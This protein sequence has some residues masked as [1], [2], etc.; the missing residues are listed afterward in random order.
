MTQQH[1]FIVTRVALF[2]V[3]DGRTI[4]KGNCACA[5]VGADGTPPRFSLVCY[6][7]QRETYCTSPIKSS[8]EHSLQFQLQVNDYASFRDDRGKKWSMM[9]LKSAQLEKFCAI[10]GAA[11]FAVSGSP[12]HNAVIADFAVPTA[13]VKVTLAHRVKVRYSAFALRRNTATDLPTVDDLLETN[14]DRPYNFQPTQSAMANPDAKGFESCCLGMSEE[15]S[16]VIVVPSRMPRAGSSPYA[17]QTDAVVF[18]VTVLRILSD[19]VPVEG[20]NTVPVVFGALTVA[21]SSSSA[22]SMNRGALTLVSP[23]PREAEAVPAPVSGTTGAVGSGIPAEHMAMIQKCGAQINAITTQARDMHDKVVAFADD[24]KQSVNRPKPSAL[25]NESLQ[26]NIKQMV[27]EHDRLKDEIVRRDEL[28]RSIDDRNRDLQK[29]VDT[30]AMVAQQLMDEKNNTV[31]AASDLK[32]D[33]DR[34]VMKLQEQLTHVGAERDDVNRHLLTVKKLLE[35]SDNELREIRGKIDVHL[36]QAQSLAS[37]LDVADDTLGEERSRRKALE[38]KVGALQDEIRTSEADLHMKVAQLEDLNRKADGERTYQVQIMEDERTRRQYEAQQL[39]SEIVQELQQREAKFLADRAR[40]AEDHFKRGHDE[41]KQIGRGNAKIDV[42][43]RMEELVLD[44]Q[45]A[46]TELD[47]Y[48]T[49]HRQATEES[50]AENRRLEC[51]VNELKKSVDE[52]TRR[53]AQNEFNLHA[54]RLKVRNAEEALLV[55]LTSV[56]HR[57]F[58]PAEPKDLIA[59]LTAIKNGD[60]PLLRF[61]QDAHQ[62]EAAAAMARRLQLIDTTA[63]DLYLQTVSNT[64]D[65]F[66]REAA[67]MNDTF[68]ATFGAMWRQRDAAAVQ[69]AVDEESSTRA[70]VEGESDSFFAELTAFFQQQWTDREALLADEEEARLSSDRDADEEVAAFLSALRAF[71]ATQAE[72]RRAVESDHEVSYEAFLTNADSELEVHFADVRALM[73]RQRQ[74]RSA[75]EE[76]EEQIR[77]QLVSECEAELQSS[78][79]GFFEFVQSIR[80]DREALEAAEVDGRRPVEEDETTT[81]AVIVALWASQKEERDTLVAEEEPL[82]AQYEADE[83]TAYRKIIAEHEAKIYEDLIAEQNEFFEGETA[84]RRAIEEDLQ[85]EE[86][87]LRTQLEASH[88]EHAARQKDREAHEKALQDCIQEESSARA[89]VEKSQGTDFQGIER[90]RKRDEEGPQVDVGVS[91]LNRGSVAMPPPPLGGAGAIVSDDSDSDGGKPPPKRAV[92]PKK[93]AA[94]K[95]ATVAPAN[96]FGSDSDDDAPKPPPKKMAKKMMMKPAKMFDSDS[97]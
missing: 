87:A 61:Q 91:Q 2:E 83:A 45:R 25:T 90:E 15:S 3:V 26:S 95:A 50:L 60:N 73:E 93:A 96:L 23:T 66:L 14:G 89:A 27:M 20:G 6:N 37:R 34:V 44:A 11:F 78:A 30:A 54:A 65:A 42:E 82:R 13:D 74:E 76:E 75:V 88:A 72:E 33:R 5:I 80:R 48:K 64:T 49:E 68:R 59:A 24:W 17:S 28:I 56:A 62:E 7:D 31:A 18:V 92:P 41:G 55:S 69:N 79:G 8:N 47:A 19:I 46:K 53:K 21:N 85:S 97:D 32:L 52:A 12:E 57:L 36:V 70:N 86:A 81:F 84:Q 4:E 40:T 39:R 1:V 22:D 94:Q 51:I 38:A 16:R 63:H 9:F 35:V 43:A 58:R 77:P 71:M 67:A 10:L 29:R